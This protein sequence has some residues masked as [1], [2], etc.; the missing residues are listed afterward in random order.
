MWRR[1]RGRG[2]GRGGFEGKIA[3]C[4]VATGRKSLRCW[5]RRVILS[6]GNNVKSCGGHN[7]PYSVIY[8]LLFCAIG[9]LSLWDCATCMLI[10]RSARYLKLFLYNQINHLLLHCD[11]RNCLF[12]SFIAISTV[13]RQSDLPGRVSTAGTLKVR[14]GEGADINIARNCRMLKEVSNI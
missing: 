8:M 7:S 12:T 5:R 9:T 1:G 2:R 4:T 3:E 13:Y 10:C 6:L 11:V 14:R